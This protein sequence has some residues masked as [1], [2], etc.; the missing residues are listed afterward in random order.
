MF[1]G[2][3]SPRW[4]GKLCKGAGNQMEITETTAKCVIQRQC[5]VLSDC[6]VSVACVVYIIYC[7]IVETKCSLSLSLSLSRPSFPSSVPLQT[8]YIL[9]CYGPLSYAP[10]LH[11][12]QAASV[13]SEIKSRCIRKRDSTCPPTN[14]PIYRKASKLQDVNPIHLPVSVYSLSS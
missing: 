4:D 12:R 1:Y 5:L 10:L 6:G 14:Y 9:I 3:A 11:G 2:C 7:R 8:Y 13:L